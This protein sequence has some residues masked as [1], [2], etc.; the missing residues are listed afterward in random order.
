MLLTCLFEYL[1]LYVSQVGLAMFTVHH[2]IGKWWAND[3]AVCTHYTLDLDKI[4]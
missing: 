1:L 4:K 3:K 2:S